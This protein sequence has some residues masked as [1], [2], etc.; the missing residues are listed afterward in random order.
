MPLACQALLPPELRRLSRRIAMSTVASPAEKRIYL[1]NIRWP[2]YLALLEDLGAHRG[3]LTYDRGRLE[4]VSPSK[5]HEHLK[6][7]VG[8]LI[9]AF[10]EE[11]GIKIQSVSS[12]TLNREDLQQGVEA[13]ECYYVRNEP[14]VRDKEEIDLGRDPP[15][16]LVVE[17]EVARRILRRIPIYAAMG[18]AELWRYDGKALR[19]C[20]LQEDGQYLETGKSQVFPTLPL[21]ELARFLDDRARADETELVR[22]FRRWVRS[23]FQ[24]GG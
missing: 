21:E 15:P 18:I 14:A 12:T 8:R 13:D 9:E 17:V 23:H 6:R 2:T 24:I 1:E 10:T 11:L 22:S 20:R 19:V 5:K 4:I 16:D 7:L 3:R